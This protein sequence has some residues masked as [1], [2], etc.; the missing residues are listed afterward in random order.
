MVAGPS[1]SLFTP[2][3][4]MLQHAHQL[5]SL[6]TI[7]KLDKKNSTSL[8]AFVAPRLPFFA[9]SGDGFACLLVLALI[10]WIVM[11]AVEIGEKPVEEEETLKSPKCQLMKVE[12]G[13]SFYRVTNLDK[14][15]L[16]VKVEPALGGE[17]RLS[18]QT[19]GF[20]YFYRHRKRPRFYLQ[21][22]LKIPCSSFVWITK[23]TCC[24]MTRLFLHLFV[25][26]T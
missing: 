9:T 10:V 24:K 15:P 21:S 18:C 13:S 8:V 16:S 7:K 14:R 26:K 22:I 5:L 19:F 23:S 4:F 2:I 17:V 11:S 20:K 1:S 6:S 25:Q 12:D 3:I